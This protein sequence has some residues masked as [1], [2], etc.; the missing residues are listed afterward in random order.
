MPERQKNTSSTKSSKRKSKFDIGVYD[1]RAKRAKAGIVLFTYTPIPKGVCVIEYVGRVI[2][3]A[4][5]YTSRSKYLF[6]VTAKKTLDGRPRI[7]KAGYINHSC[8]PNCEPQVYK[9]RVFI[10]SRRAIKEGEELTYDYGKSY[11]NEH[12]KPLGCRCVKC[13]GE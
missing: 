2:P 9:G 4:E 1:L 12:I 8:R 3:E 13:K 7:N 6:E 11:W 5:E 10:L